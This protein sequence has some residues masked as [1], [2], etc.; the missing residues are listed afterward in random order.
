MRIKD[1]LR[2]KGS[3]VATVTADALVRS[4]LTQ[5]AVHG[6]GAMV[7][8]SAQGELVGIVSERDVV[9][10]LNDRGSDLL[11]ATVESIMTVDVVTCSPDDAVDSVMRVMTD[12]RVRHVP[13]MVEGGLAGI[14]SIGDIVK[15]RITDLQTTAEQLESYI[16]GSR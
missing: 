15:S 6:V 5:L 16:T 10:R 2:H 13:V 9:R 12:R 8:V 7:V 1:V 3:D 11:D 4:L 14:V